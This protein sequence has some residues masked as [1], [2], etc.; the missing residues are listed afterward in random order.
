MHLRRI[1]L[2]SLVLVLGLC[3]IFAHAA[4]IT[5]NLNGTLDPNLNNGPDCLSAAGTTAT[6]SATIKS[7]ATPESTTSDSATYKLPPKSV[8]ATVGT[9]SFTNS[10]AWKM[11]VTVTSSHDSITF[12]GTGPSTSHVTAVAYLPKGTFT[13][14]ALTHPQAISGTINIKTPKSYLSYSVPILGCSVTKLGFTGTI[15]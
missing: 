8:T 1:Q 12:S 4:N 10:S 15:N 14:G 5:Y 6:A 11:K 3:P 7:T 13:N 9:T 2:L